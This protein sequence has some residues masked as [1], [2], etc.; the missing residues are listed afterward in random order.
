[1]AA[2]FPGVRAASSNA[3]VL[4]GRQRIKALLEIGRAV[5]S[6]PG[7]AV[8]T[9]MAAT[10]A[11][12]HENTGL[13]TGALRAA[14]PT[15][16]PVAR[17]TLRGAVVEAITYEPG[18]SGL[19]LTTFPRELRSRY[20]G[21]RAQFEA[22]GI[23]PADLHWPTDINAFAFWSVGSL[24]CMLTTNFDAGPDI[25]AVHV[26]QH[27]PTLQDFLRTPPREVTL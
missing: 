27:C 25:W 18:P 24:K 26:H 11:S 22:S 3:Q 5:A 20:V 8:D 2:H 19:H 4:N 14:L 16:Q 17:K 21:T 15:G 10:L 9:A 23:V 7:V 13:D 1:M 12:I 6:V